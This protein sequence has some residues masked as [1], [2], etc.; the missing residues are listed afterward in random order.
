MG[1]ILPWSYCLFFSVTSGRA[2]LNNVT[3]L[4]SVFPAVSGR[5]CVFPDTCDKLP[6]SNFGPARV[7]SEMYYHLSNTSSF[8]VIT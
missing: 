5:F 2:Q 4:L 1:V 3:I 8:Y 6:T 7:L